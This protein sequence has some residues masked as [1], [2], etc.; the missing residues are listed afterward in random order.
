MFGRPEPQSQ[1]YFAID[2]ESWIEPDHPLRG[3]K[4]RVD[5]ILRSMRPKFKKANSVIGRPSVPPE[6]LLKALLL[7]SLYSI[8]SERQLMADIRMNLL[9][10]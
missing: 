4:K 7:Q 8:R 5:E 10:R 6:M 3:V 1:I 2:I 9:Y